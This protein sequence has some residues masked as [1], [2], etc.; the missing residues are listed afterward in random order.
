MRHAVFLFSL[1]C[2]AACGGPGREG[3][4][5]LNTGDC[6]NGYQC[7]A[8]SCRLAVGGL[9]TFPT[10][11]VM[12]QCDEDADCG[13]LTCS[14]G[15]CVCTS[16]DHCT[17]SCVDGVC[18]ECGTDND[19]DGDQVC[20][21][22][23][24]QAACEGAHQCPAFH[25]CE[26]GRCNFIGCQTHRECVTYLSDARGFCD[27]STEP[28]TCARGCDSDFDCEPG[29][30][31]NLA[32]RMICVG[33]QCQPLGCESDAECHALMGATQFGVE[34]RDLSGG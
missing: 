24:C 2:L 3:D 15:M 33:G 21:D 10:E 26:S 1:V 11:C 23:A 29:G 22:G 25:S 4:T 31:T 17:G 27:G 7:R 6:G 12:L 34:C 28:P 13:A 14:S 19:C 5:C 18:V 9:A 8:G 30:G 20:N 32:T 16:D